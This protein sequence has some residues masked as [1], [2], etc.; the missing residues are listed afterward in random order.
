MEVMGPGLACNGGADEQVRA[1]LT[2]GQ[3]CLAR[4]RFFCWHKSVSQ[5][6]FLC[7]FGPTEHTVVPMMCPTIIMPRQQSQPCSIPR[8][9]QDSRRVRT[10]RSV[11]GQ[12]ARGRSLLPPPDAPPPSREGP[13]AHLRVIRWS[14]RQDAGTDGGPGAPARG[15]GPQCGEAGAPEATGPPW[16]GDV[17]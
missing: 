17:A 9:R 5:G 7:T 13:A 1:C 4:T 16:M 2:L 14:P 3:C 6:Q 10:A 12:F 8:S 11:A 15:Q